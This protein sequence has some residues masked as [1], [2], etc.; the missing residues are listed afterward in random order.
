MNWTPPPGLHTATDWGG[1]PTADS[2]MPDHQV[3]CWAAEQ[4]EKSYDRP[5]FMA[6]G[7][8]R[9]HVPLH[10]PQ[11][12]FDLHPLERVALPPPAR[13]HRGPARNRDPV[14]RTVP[15]AVVSVHGCRRPVAGERP[16]LSGVRLV[17]RPHDRRR[18]R[19][20]GTRPPRRQH[21]VVLVSDHGYHVGTK[22]MWSK[23]TLWQESTRVPLI[24]ARPDDLSADRPPRRTHRPVGHV[25]IY[26]TLLDLAG[27]PPDT[28]NE[29]VSLVRL[30]DDPDAAG[31]DATVITH[32]Y[33]NHAVRTDRWHYI[34]YADGTAELY[35]QLT[36]PNQWIN[37]ADRQQY[38]GLIDRL[39]RHLPAA[40][41]P[42]DR[43]AARNA[44]YN[45]YMQDSFE[46]HGAASESRTSE[47]QDR[48]AGV[49]ARGRGADIA[50]A[51]G[52]SRGR[53]RI[54]ARRRHGPRS[55]SAAQP[56]KP[57]RQRP[58]GRRRSSPGAVHA[59][60]PGRDD[61]HGAARS[62]R[63]TASI[64]TPSTTSARSAP[65]DA[66]CASTEC[67]I[68]T[69]CRPTAISATSASSIWRRRR[70][71]RSTKP[72]AGAFSSVPIST[73]RERPAS[74]HQ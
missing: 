44:G 43:A 47:S 27:L 49:A 5:F 39:S 65:L 9:P 74:L 24:I 66:S 21:G 22:G 53:L 28:A 19:R 11:R 56:T 20:P 42:W 15:H 71:R 40:D 72:S 48:A 36:D 34:R 10:V 31:Y 62:P 64:C 41:A 61:R 58:G 59:L 55:Q 26:P 33:G 51:R 13:S 46:R 16:G 6:V 14:F 69:R 35:D 8:V 25:D 30:L 4:L 2:L 60:P 68:R 12:W 63:T 29:G 17:R 45:D 54:R 57:A 70:S 3:A 38:A 50:Q 23:H 73:G 37:L 52:G 32:G 18:A 7:F 1:F 67:P